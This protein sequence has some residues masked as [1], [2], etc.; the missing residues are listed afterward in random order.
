MSQQQKFITGA[1]TF[2]SV[3]YMFLIYPRSFKLDN[4]IFKWNLGMR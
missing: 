4:P 2:F 1:F 3:M